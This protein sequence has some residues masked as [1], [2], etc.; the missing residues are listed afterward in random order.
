MTALPP[1]AITAATKAI[2]GE[3]IAA[4]GRSRP[5][6]SRDLAIA[7]LEAAAPHIAAAERERILNIARKY[8]AV[9]PADEPPG[10]YGSFADLIETYHAGD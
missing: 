10:A 5:R 3:Y 1:E 9:I 2:D 6:W 4:D 7:A 8:R